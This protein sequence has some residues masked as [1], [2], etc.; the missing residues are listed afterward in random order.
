MKELTRTE[1]SVRN[2]TVAISSRVI[3][4][5]MGFLVRVVFTSVLSAS[6]VGVSGLFSNIVS[7]LS[8]SELGMETAITFALYEP[9]AHK[10]IER[11]KSIMA[12]YKRLYTVVGLIILGAGI[13]MMPF[14]NL[15]IRDPGDVSDIYLIYAIYL[16]NTALSYFFIYR[17]TLMDASQ[18]RYVGVA[19]HTLF[20]ILQDIGQILILLLTKNFILFLLIYLVSTLGYNLGI[21]YSAV[22]RYPYLKDRDVN[23]FPAEEKKKIYNN[24]RAM[25]M[26]K[27]GTIIVNNTDN[28]LLSAMTGLVNAG[29]YANNFLI[30]SS[31]RQILNEAFDGIAAS[32][33]NLSVTENEQKANKIFDCAFFV[34]QWLTGFASICIFELLSP[35]CKLFFGTMYGYGFFPMLVIVL[36]FYVT[37]M[38]RA[39]IVYRDACGLFYYD[40]YK[41]VVEALINL[42]ASVLFTL[43]LGFVGVFIGTFVSTMLTSFWV[44]PFVLYKHKLHKP[45]AVYFKNYALYSL[46]FALCCFL[47]DRAL[48]FIEGAA[49]IG[50]E[51]YLPLLLLRFFFCLV[52]VNLFYLLCFFR[53]KEFALVIE[54][55][56]FIIRKKRRRE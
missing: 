54:K 45:L 27:V 11:I 32:V 13:A 24:I 34:D 5:F 23:P 30:F 20:L 29:I 14:L 44:E 31:V 19:W 6:Y 33:G 48:R 18:I 55:V 9:I 15:I 39:T 46:V 21:S 7:I 16:A 17:K 35:F 8:L 42:A 22:K 40:R 50:T 49:G 41:A 43:W 26:H 51:D 28:I 12:L 10:D 52:F 53:K 3:A 25:L 38:R 36:N 47:S 37:G 2:T 56:R 1:Y 4:I